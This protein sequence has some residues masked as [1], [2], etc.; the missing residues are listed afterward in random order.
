MIS[1]LKNKCSLVTHSYNT[2][3]SLHGAAQRQSAITGEF[4]A[5]KQKLLN[6]RVDFQ[7]T[8]TPM[9]KL[10]LEGKGGG[11]LDMSLW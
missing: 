3:S 5:T 7:T 10:S 8:Q 9:T 1:K 4:K 2:Q 11:G 6:K